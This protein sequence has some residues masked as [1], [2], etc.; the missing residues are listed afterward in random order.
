MG[1]I[2]P[3]EVEVDV[4]GRNKSYYKGL[5]YYIPERKDVNGKLRTPKNTKIK[6][7]VEHL[8]KSSAVYVDVECDCCHTPLKVRYQDYTGHN[9]DGKYYCEKCRSKVFISGKNNPRW[10]NT[11]TDYE[12][13][14]GRNYPE[15]REFV[16][17]V[18]QRDNYLCAVCGKTK[19]NDMYVH[20]LDGYNWCDEGR[21]K[22]SN[23]ITL[24]GDCH[25]EFHRVYGCGFNTKEQ[26]EEWYGKTIELN[27]E[28]IILYP[29]KEV[30][31]FE[32]DTVYKNAEEAGNILNVQKECVRAVCDKNAV[33]K[34]A[35]G[36][37]FLYKKDFD[38]MSKKEITEHK[39]SWRA[40]QS[41]EVI[42]LTTLEVFNTI[43]E[44]A[45]KYKLD[46]SYLAK[47]CK[48]P[49]TKSHG[50]LE[51]GTRLRWMYYDDYKNGEK[52]E[53][54]HSGSSKR[55]ICLNDNNVF[56]SLSKAG[57]FYGISGTSVGNV[58]KGI[59]KSTGEDKLIFRY[60]DEYLQEL[61]NKKEVI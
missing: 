34:S 43:T 18:M 39:K 15:Y 60:Y 51:D 41:K 25:K 27:D 58:C 19:S 20:H 45:N 23:G 13:E 22:L 32:T 14:N 52:E 11:L 24:C 56:Y 49:E 61:K 21:T 31:C 1:L 59:Q 48:K 57:D 55:V 37:H 16:K 12:R 35:N 53:I 5:G 6:V 36:Y 42:C 8:T 2:L 47:V 29:T 7:N 50:R 54:E 10:N 9:H 17:K 30:Y 33:V 38:S 40:K 26:F 3:Q 4:G 46:V 28:D 44:A